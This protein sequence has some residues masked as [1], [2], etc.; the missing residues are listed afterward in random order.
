MSLS[1]RFTQRRKTNHTEKPKILLFNPETFYNFFQ[2]KKLYFMTIILCPKFNQHNLSGPS[3]G[4][5]FLLETK[6]QKKPKSEKKRFHFRL[7]FPAP[8]VPVSFASLNQPSEVPQAGR[9]GWK[10]ILNYLSSLEPMVCTLREFTLKFNQ[11]S[12]YPMQSKLT[13]S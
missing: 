7:K 12:L 13:A 6:K 2:L 11:K 5:M 3:S 8:P 10:G 9:F 4:G 1:D